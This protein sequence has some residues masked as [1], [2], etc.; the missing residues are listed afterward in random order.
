MLTHWFGRS[1]DVPANQ[2]T[3]NINNVLRGFPR[4]VDL[5]Y[6]G[7]IYTDMYIYMYTHTNVRVCVC[8][9]S[10][11]LDLVTKSVCFNVYYKPFNCLY[12]I[13]LTILLI[14]L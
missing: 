1:K 2:S 14:N 10:M 5:V 7:F 4:V 11:I 9:Y 13:I 8:V 3:R 6:C 12:I